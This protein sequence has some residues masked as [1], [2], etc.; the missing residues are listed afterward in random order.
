MFYHNLGKK[1]S[2]R[3]SIPTNQ[4]DSMNYSPRRTVFVISSKK[5]KAIMKKTA[6]RKSKVFEV[7]SFQRFWTP[8]APY[9]STSF[10]ISKYENGARSPKFDSNLI[11]NENGSFFGKLIQNPNCLDELRNP[12]R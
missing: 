1:T 3:V 4:M 10:F 7:N 9:F 5:N 8:S 2:L 12:T 11:S 6:L